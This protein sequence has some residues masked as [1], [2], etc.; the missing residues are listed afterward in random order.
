MGTFSGRF[1]DG[2]TARSHAVRV[3]V[4]RAYLDIR[5]E[6]DDLSP[7]NWWLNGLDWT[8]PVL[9]GDPVTITHRD[10]PDALLTVSDAKFL[11]E[12][13][14]FDPEALGKSARAATRRHSGLKTTAT[15][16]GALALC[17]VA[18]M[19][20]PGLLA[21]L[22]PPSWERHLGDSA[23]ASFLSH[24]RE[25]H[26]TAGD[27]TVAVLT[28]RLQDASRG[29]FD[30]TL[31]VV[32]S[33]MVNAFAMPGGQVVLF[34]GLIDKAESPDEVAGV[35]AHETAHVV[36]R[37]GTQGLIRSTALSVAV[38]T[39]T[40]STDGGAFTG[41][42][43]AQLTD[44]SFSR[45]QEEEA[46]RVGAD[47]M[48]RA[49][50]SVAGMGQFFERMQRDHGDQIPALLST[51]PRP[52]DRAQQLARERTNQERQGT[53]TTAALTEEQWQALRG[54]CG[55]PAKVPAK[56]SDATSA[57]PPAE[58]AKT[59]ASPAPHHPPRQPRGRNTASADS[60]AHA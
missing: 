20:L 28:R 2:L 10:F 13:Q 19:V 14:R 9:P 18:V 47:I 7:A 45:V 59:P 53:P 15:A 46:D 56:A 52:A 30:L 48:R 38:S 17:A 35:L 55:V 49:G 23:A 27:D 44:L 29:P 26:S 12:I 43:A 60:G 16:A 6:G 24:A 37:H 39:L 25:C 1:C 8:D 58:T 36:R 32:K 11:A 5:P 33:D 41:R 4:T 57:D 22:I 3:E 50:W 42:V 31:H 54:I 40:G 21:P 34:S 51:H